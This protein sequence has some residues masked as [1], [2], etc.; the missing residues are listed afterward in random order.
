M[1]SDD[2]EHTCLVAQA[3]IASSHEPTLFSKQFAWRLRCWLV[4]LSVGLYMAT[5]C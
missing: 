2:T 1:F 4:A 5:F 3:L